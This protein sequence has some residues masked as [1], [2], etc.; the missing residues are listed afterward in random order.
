MFA[1]T[2][3]IS[4]KPNTLKDFT[5]VLDKEVVPMLRKQ[6]GFR[7]EICLASDD[8]IHVT[9]I[10]LWDSKQ[11]AEAYIASTYPVV[12]KTLDKFLDGT[13]KVSVWN[14]INSTTHKLTSATVV[15]A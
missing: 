8:N 4:L 15:A 12:L 13:P 5:L 10:S 2:L 6:A 3:T 14:V 11:Q 9:A 7:D 1:R